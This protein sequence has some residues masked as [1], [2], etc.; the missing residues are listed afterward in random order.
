MSTDQATERKRLQ[1]QEGNAKNRAL[2]ISCPLCS[3]PA[4]DACDR[5]L[6][7]ARVIHALRVLAAYGVDPSAR[8]T[9]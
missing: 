9:R 4:G 3:A 6:S 8:R 7:K 5:E 1:R 2:K